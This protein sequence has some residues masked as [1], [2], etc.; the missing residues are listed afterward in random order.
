MGDDINYEG[1]H[2]R[3]VRAFGKAA[4]HEC[5][6]GKTASH[7]S[8]SNE[9]RKEKTGPEGHGRV[10]AWCPHVDCYEALCVSCHKI[11]DLQ[12]AEVAA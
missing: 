5:P 4:E 6:C 1:I 9:C 7:W 10:V 8:Y 11:K 2:A 3:V 12:K